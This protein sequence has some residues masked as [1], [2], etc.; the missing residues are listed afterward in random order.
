MAYQL[1]TGLNRRKSIDLHL[2]ILNEGRLERLCRKEG[3]TCYLFNEQEI[4]FPS[5]AYKALKIARKIKPD[6]IHSH[7]YKENILAAL[8]APGC[9]LPKLIATQHGRT[10]ADKHV[11]HE[12]IISDLNYAC[13]QWIFRRVVAVSNDTADYLLGSCG[14]KQS[15][16]TIIPNGIDLPRN[17]HRA[18]GKRFGQFFT[19]G[20]AGRLFPVKQFDRLIEIAKEVFGE[21]GP[22]RFVIAGDGPEKKK[23][24]TLIARYRLT[25]HVHLLGHVE[26]MQD[27]YKNIDLYVNTSLHEGAPMT[28]IEAMRNGLPVIAFGVAGLK[29]II[30]DGKD[31]YAIPPYDNHQFA[32][33]IAELTHAPQQLKFLGESARKKV[34]DHFSTKGM[35]DKYWAMYENLARKQGGEEC[36]LR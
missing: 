17:C 13:M 31:G 12:K 14:L 18:N 9:G 11:F 25:E 30:A 7:R 22:I 33:K 24:E 5:L 27:F 20:S 2:I 34:I 3:I 26:D 23:L 4:S 16:L 36:P 29:E 19:V 35:V 8:I 32:L 6:I 28:I 15:K 10:E 21:N 1:L